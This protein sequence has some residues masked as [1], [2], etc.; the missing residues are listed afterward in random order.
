MT[1]LAK[2]FRRLTCFSFGDATTR[3][4]TSRVPKVCG[5]IGV[6]LFPA[7]AALAQS[8]GGGTDPATMV[9][10]ICTFILGPFGQSLA[11]LGIVAIGVSWMFGRA[12]LGLVAG[13]VGGIVIMFGASFLGQTLT[14]GSG[15]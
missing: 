15:G 5:T 11:V 8:A 3:V 14:G 7:E 6:S 4:I 1:R 9:N 13:V 2:H 10:N 12:S